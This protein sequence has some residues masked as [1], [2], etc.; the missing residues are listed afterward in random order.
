MFDP[1]TEDIIKN[2]PHLNGIDV[3]RLPLELTKIYSNIV[4][5][6]SQLERGKLQLTEQNYLEYLQFLDKL[7]VGLE[8]L[9]FQSRY[10]SHRKNIA[11]VI[12]T[13]YKL[14]SMFID[15]E[16]AKCYVN[17]DIVS[18]NLISVLLFL[19]A[20][21]FAGSIEAVNSI[22]E[23]NDYSGKLVLLLRIL[24]SG[25]ISELSSIELM[26]PRLDRN[27]MQKYANDLLLWNL[28]ASIQN[29]KSYF[30][31]ESTT[32]DL[33]KI[34]QVIDLCSFK[35]DQIE[36][37]DTYFGVIKLAKYLKLAIINLEKYSV[38]HLP[39]PSDINEGAWKVFLKKLCD[40]GRAFLWS[41]HV[42]AVGK[43][44]LEKGISSV[45]TF[46]TGAGKSTLV[47]L[48]IACSVLRG[49]RV[50]YIVP[51]HALESQV[52]QKVRK[53]F[54]GF[55]DRLDDIFIG[56]EYSQITDVET[57]KILVATPERFLSLLSDSALSFKDVGLFVFDEF[58]LIGYEQTDNLRNLSAMLMLLTALNTFH[59]ADFVL[60]SAMVKNG[61]SIVGWITD[62][63][64]RECLLLDEKWKPT[65]QLQGC[66]LYKKSQIDDLEKIISKGTD[67]GKKLERKLHATPYCLFSLKTKWDSE[68][69]SNYNLLRL[70]N[71]DVPLKIGKYLNLTANRNEVAANIATSFA[72]ANLKVLVF[73]ASPNYTG[74]IQ[75][76]IDAELGKCSLERFSN[77]EEKRQLA[78]EFG[79]F[80]ISYLKDTSCAI[81][82]G[83]LLPLERKL[84]EEFFKK[85]KVK[86]MVATP[87]LA[88][89]I[90]LPA[91]M[92][93]IAG[94]NRF[95]PNGKNMESLQAHEILNAVGRAGRAGLCS[96][97][98]AILIPGEVVSIN[99]NLIDSHWFKLKDNIFSKGDACF[100]IEDPLGVLM[101]EV[102]ENGHPVNKEQEIFIHRLGDEKNDDKSL[103]NKSFAAYKAKANSKLQQFSALKTKFLPY[104]DKLG[105]ENDDSVKLSIRF[106][107]SSDVIEKLNWFIA[108]YNDAEIEN[109]HP[110]DLVGDFFTSLSEEF[111]SVHFGEDDFES[112]ISS[113]KAIKNLKTICSCSVEDEFQS[114]NFVQIG[115]VVEA[116]MQGKN[117]QEL[118]AMMNHPLRKDNH[119]NLVRNFVLSAI[120]SIS[121]IFGII[122]VLLQKSYVTFGH[123]NDEFPY[124]LKCIATL[125]K[126]GVDSMEK[127]KFMKKNHLMRVSCHKRFHV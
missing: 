101:K 119:L 16:N 7:I 73:V 63:T 80:F 51:T 87:T 66:L 23:T 124:E 97:G 102:V 21:D 109:L 112:L 49:E 3:E 36:Q 5:V 114:A 13:A 104:L 105:K 4:S 70:L 19:V 17:F 48:K 26:K 93:I 34:N 88:Q 27:D 43:G 121:Y 30:Y 78:D 22:E 79:D 58:H 50:V 52:N 82:H 111:L 18:S 8:V 94:D 6:K 62:C 75:R 40:N 15:K 69:A 65:R 120:P 38:F 83:L 100:E 37:E 117:Y 24:L 45:I 116:Y 115:K 44:F 103:L 41:N 12:A 123:S 14:K 81:H 11:F 86:V 31:G 55:E 89:G 92:V 71:S 28:C 113:P 20:D 127:L 59:E 85:G 99:E 110:I 68:E 47:D 64:Q 60:I 1:V 56:G 61:K 72:L 98:S 35:I 77:N 125:V 39:S 84:M 9:L 46:P 107:L 108:Q 95:D 91:D 33:S 118:Y 67:R 2:I 10:L 53:L 74:S 54:G 90:N 122:S 76:L 96:Y 42:N 32:L 106:G 29:A 57:D 25:R 126:E